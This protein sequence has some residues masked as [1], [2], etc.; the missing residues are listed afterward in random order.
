MQTG[1]K[2]VFIDT[3]LF[4]YLLEDSP[5]YGNKSENFFSFCMSKNIAMHT[6]LITYLE[7]CVKPYRENNLILIDKFKELIKCSGINM[8]ETLTLFDCD[9]A[10]KLRAENISLKNFDA[11]QIATALNNNCDIFMS[12][13]KKLKTVKDIKIYT[14]DDWQIQSVK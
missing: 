11:I 4:I 14:L 7:F 2:S 8:S 12:N 9:I 10:S 1:F 6:G 3:A 13:D 5:D